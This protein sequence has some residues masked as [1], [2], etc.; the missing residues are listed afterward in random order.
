MSGKRRFWLKVGV[1]VTFSLMV[2]GYQ[3]LGHG[4]GFGFW[5]GGLSG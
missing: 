2:W 3:N 1:L 4:T 5:S